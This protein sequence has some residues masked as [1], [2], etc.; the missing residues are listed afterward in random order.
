MCIQPTRGSWA[1]AAPHSQRGGNPDVS[2]SF[3]KNE[4]MSISAIAAAGRVMRLTGRSAQE[5]LVS[6]SL[7]GQHITLRVSLSVA[8]LDRNS[9]GPPPLPQHRGAG[10]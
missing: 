10:T 2:N 9:A 6:I 8:G 4:S 7:A 1:P 5:S 3:E